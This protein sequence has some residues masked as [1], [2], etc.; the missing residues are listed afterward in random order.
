MI[1]LAGILMNR[2]Y[3]LAI[4]DMDHGGKVVRAEDATVSHTTLRQRN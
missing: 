3:W 1:V 4:M 2:V